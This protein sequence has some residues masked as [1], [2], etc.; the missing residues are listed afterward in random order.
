[1]LLNSRKFMATLFVATLLLLFSGRESAGIGID[2]VAQES[3]R[4]L[5]ESLTTGPD[6]KVNLLLNKWGEYLRSVSTYS[7]S[8]FTESIYVLQQEYSQFVEQLEQCLESSKDLRKKYDPKWLDRLI[9]TFGKAYLKK[10][11]ESVYINLQMIVK[12][13]YENCCGQIM[14]KLFYKEAVLYGAYR[15]YF[16]MF[17]DFYNIQ[18]P[19]FQD[20]LKSRKE[21][22][23]IFLKLIDD[24]S[25]G[26]MFIASQ[27]HSR[28]LSEIAAKSSDVAIYE[29]FKKNLLDCDMDALKAIKDFKRAIKDN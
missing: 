29:Y 7:N 2:K 1:M 17:L 10:K 21:A 18:P 23:E 11:G 3:S 20:S 24:H 26:K 8:E 15:D 6:P 9:E 16:K 13:S 22:T 4:N 5:L 28:Q 14:E 12:G 27:P 19:A 25:I